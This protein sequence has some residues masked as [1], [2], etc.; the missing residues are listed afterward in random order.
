M[1][2]SGLFILFAIMENMLKRNKKYW[3]FSIIII[4]ACVMV[5]QG[6]SE[7]WKRWLDRDVRYII[8]PKERQIFLSLKS[9]K[10]REAFRKAFWLQRDPTPGTPA[11]EVRIEHYRRL[12]YAEEYLGRDTAGEGWETD[13]GR[14]YILLG[15]PID[16]QRFYETS[17]NTV[18]MEL[19]QYKGDA[20]LGF[21]PVFYILFYQDDR[22]GEF[23]LYNPSFH[24]PQ[25]LIRDNLR[26]PLQR[27]DAYDQLM[28]VSAE[29]AAASLSLIP[30][31]GAG[32]S[33]TSQS[34]S[35]EMLLTRIH[36]LPEKK[37]DPEWADAFARHKEVILT[38]YSVQYV[39]SHHVF[40]IHQEK[41]RNYLHYLIEPYKMSMSRYDDKIFTSLQLNMKI[42]D[43]NGNTVHQ[44]E[45]GI[46][47][48]MTLDDFGKVRGRLS[49]IGDL[50]ALI[51]GR[52]DVDILLQNTN[53]KEFSSAEAACFSPEAGSLSLSPVLLLYDETD[54]SDS[55]RSL[56]F[57]FGD[58]R[59]FPNIRRTYTQADN[60]LV[61]FELYNPMMNMDGF[62]IDIKI[63]REDEELYADRIPVGKKR[64]FTERVPL[65]QYRPGYYTVQAALLD[66]DGN[67]VEKNREEFI[68]SQR[69]AIPRPWRFNKAYPPL[70]HPYFSIIRA[71]QY[72]G[73]E[74]YA[75]II[76]ELS[77]LYDAAAPN[78]EVAK[79]LAKAHMGKE[80][81]SQAI[82]VLSPLAHIQDLES[83]EMLGT[84][85]LLSGRYADA[86]T[87]LEKALDTGG[88]VIGII[89]AL[90]LAHLKLNRPG[91]ALV[92][93]KRSI[94]L[95][96][97]QEEIRE[98]I[99]RIEK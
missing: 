39:K 85:Y 30:G 41:G 26:Q 65:K 38:D 13:R 8:T 59:L 63:D 36:Q 69:S 83:L 60:L 86:V 88:E 24:E 68:I 3:L 43:R 11:N 40:F 19:W 45:K 33:R 20:D 42:S 4:F 89:N 17:A 53:S 79:L 80:D 49:A 14:M 23:R 81:Y 92:Y 75:K 35:S 64:A 18:S 7:D 12:Q 46:Q 16:I 77:P 52:F 31:T 48:E 22:F 87:I 28:R 25:I 78:K 9:E 82:E 74:D 73:R 61:Y 94:K 97:D 71:H 5:A 54:A 72:L 66:P 62:R 91:E 93:F 29:V 1:N 34:L 55:R 51:G 95:Q 47:I 99:S 27:K 50:T 21:P 57:Q 84:S 32:P 98:H 58:R 6:Q 56:P 67:V 90:G 70:Y 10:E 96:P 15:E 76:Q 44:E 37:A 2:S